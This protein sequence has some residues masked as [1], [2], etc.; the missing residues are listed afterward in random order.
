MTLLTNYSMYKKLFSI[1]DPKFYQKIWTLQKQC[2]LIILYNNLQ[3]N[4]GNFLSTICFPKKSTKVDPPNIR[5]FLMD[6]LREK[7]ANFPS[8]I[9]NYYMRLVQ[10][11]VFMNS[12]SLKDSDAM[13]MDKNFLKIRANQIANGIQLAT[14]IKRSL[15]VYL[16]LFQE[17]DAVMPKSAFQVI[18]QAVEML[19]AIEIEFKTKKFLINKWVI[20]INRYTCEF[21]M[22]QIERGMQKVYAMKEKQRNIQNNMM[23]L[24]MNVIECYKGG[25]N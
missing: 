10:W 11:I 2:P 22:R 14:E 16:L 21:I 18:I 25:Y 15:K 20:L 19:K 9:Q 6:Q 3:V 7:D 4:P 1:E 23:E 17:N 13:L 24:M 5:T 8:L 12:D